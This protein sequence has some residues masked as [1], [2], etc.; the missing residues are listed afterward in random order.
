M[1]S[2]LKMFSGIFIYM[3]ACNTARYAYKELVNVITPPNVREYF[4]KYL[5]SFDMKKS[6]HD[7]SNLYTNFAFVFYFHAFNYLTILE[8][9]PAPIVRPHLHELQRATQVSMATG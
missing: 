2:N 9:T 3:R 5:R 4:V 6:V 7:D 1:N 8:I